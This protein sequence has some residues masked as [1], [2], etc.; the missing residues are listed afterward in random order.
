MTKPI[1]EHIFRLVNGIWTDVKGNAGTL[2]DYLGERDLLV[3]D[4]TQFARIYD[5]AANICYYYRANG[6]AVKIVEW[7]IDPC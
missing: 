7:R 5:Y 2:A 3:D 6:G 4:K 1:A